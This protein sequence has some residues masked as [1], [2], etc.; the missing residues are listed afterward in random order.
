MHIG[1]KLEDYKNV[2]LYFDGWDVKSVNIYE[3]G[4]VSWKDILTDDMN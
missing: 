2:Q 1:K 4:D 3:S